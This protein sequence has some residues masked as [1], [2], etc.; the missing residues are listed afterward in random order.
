[1]SENIWDKN[2][3]NIQNVELVSE[4]KKS[5]IDYA[6]SV[7]VSRALP[8]VR[9]GLKPVH[10]RILYTMYEDN[11][12]P[13]RMFRK[14]AT[15]VGDVLGR[16]HPHGDASVYD[17]LVRLAQDFSLRYPLVEGHGNFGSVDGDPP[18]YTEARMSKISLEMLTD[19]DK[20]TVN[21][22]PNFDNQRKEPEVL[23]SRFPNLLV[24]GSQGIAV[25]MAT[26]IPPHNLSETIDAVLCVLDDEFADLDDLMEH[27]KGPDFPTKGIIIGRSGIRAAYGTGRGRIK[28]R[29]RAEI[30]EMHGNRSRIVVTELPYMVNKARL[31]ENIADLHKDKR[32]DMI[33]GLRDES[34]RDGMKIVIELKREAN[35][36]VVLNQLY[37][38]TQMQTT[39]GIILLALSNGQPKVFTLR[40][41][42]D[43]YIAH[44]KDI[45]V[46]RTRYDLRKAEERAH[47]L[48]GLHIAV[49]NIDEVIRIIRSSY[50]DARQRLMDRFSLSE[51]QAQ[52]ILEMQLRRLQG[53][54]IEKIETELEQIK[55]KIAD[56]LDI[57]AHDTRVVEIIKAELLEIKKKYGD[58]RRTEIE[59]IEDEID[60]EDLIDEEDCVYTLT[61]LGYIKRLSADTYR[62]QKRGGKGISAMTTR[63]EDFAETV[64]IASTHDQILFFTDRGRLYRKKGYMVPEAGRTAKG[65]NIINLLPLEPEENVTAM[66]AIREFSETEYLMMIT[67]AGVVKRCCLSDLNT[68]RKGGIR[69]INLAEDDSLISVF[70]TDGKQ[71][72]I[73]ATREGKAICFDENDCRPMGRTASGV[74]GIWLDEGDYC[75]GA[76]RVNE[77]ST[78]LTVTE[79]GYGKRTRIEEYMRGPDG[80]KLPQRRG[81]KG[82]NNYRLTAATGKVAAVKV[83]DENDDVLMISDDGTIIRMETEDINLYSRTTQGV[84]VMR[85]SEGAKVISVA[86]IARETAEGG[87]EEETQKSE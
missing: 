82:L 25:G 63:D 28:V 86:K 39:F 43:E 47:I 48:E 12:T 51:I 68:V 49:N 45:I 8:D 60:I 62:S 67:R 14:S 38:M 66:M 87:E 64:F 79:N 78:L 27:I 30:E 29:A 36:Q 44:Q 23:P 35:P 71:A 16:Y 85:L 46:R 34:G 53:L 4:M 81:G 37:S 24:N 22:L 9:D 57:L 56:Y 26:N 7:I 13:D 6:M 32:L 3:Q 11:L 42:L 1:M 72:V 15:T 77:N 55:L 10:R 50:N 58:A 80:E 19:I 54:E 75:I 52:A 33:S 84:R 17:A 2:R 18:A 59:L 76:A 5:Y 69:A 20:E 41:M 83:V 65:M 73:I 70:K 31:I 21:F 40:E 61:H 74:R